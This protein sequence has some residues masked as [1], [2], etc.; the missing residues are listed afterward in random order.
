MTRNICLRLRLLQLRPSSAVHQVDG[1]TRNLCFWQSSLSLL[2]GSIPTP[3]ASTVDA[4]TVGRPEA[5][6]RP[7][8]MAKPM[9]ADRPVTDAV[10]TG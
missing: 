6:R 5:A 8:A 4:L 7:W 9:P 3:L 2:S 1:Y 10:F